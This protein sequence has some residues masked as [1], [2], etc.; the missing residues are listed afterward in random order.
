MLALKKVSGVTHV[1]DCFTESK[2][3]CMFVEHPKGDSLRNSVKR[4]RL[5]HL[6][7]T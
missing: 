2:N 1:V 3:F 7:E 5:T 4:L 6:K